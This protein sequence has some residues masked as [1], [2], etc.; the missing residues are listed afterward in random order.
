MSTKHKWLSLLKIIAASIGVNRML[1]L[2]EWNRG[3]FAAMQS[4]INI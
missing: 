1:T 2:L 4:L 3:K